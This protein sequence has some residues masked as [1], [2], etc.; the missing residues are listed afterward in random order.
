MAVLN[1]EDYQ[2]AI[3]Q[4]GK[5]VSELNKTK[6]SKYGDTIIGDLE[7]L[8]HTTIADNKA[9]QLMFSVHQTDN[10]VTTSGF[11]RV[12]DDHDAYNYGTNMVIQSGGNMIVG[13]GESAQSFYDG[14][15]ISHTS[16]HMYLTSDAQMYFITNC[17]TLNGIADRKTVVLNA[18]P[19][20]YSTNTGTSSLG[21]TTYP[22]NNIIGDGIR[23]RYISSHLGYSPLI[24][25]DLSSSW[26]SEYPVGMNYD[27]TSVLNQQSSDKSW[28][29][30]VIKSICA[31]Y[32]NKKDVT[33]RGQLYPNSKGWFEIF[34]YDTSDLLNGYPSCVGT[35]RKHDTTLWMFSHSATNG[36]WRWWTNKP[37]LI[38]KTWTSQNYVNE[39][40]FNRLYCYDIG[41]AYIV[42]GNMNVTQGV[43]YGTTYTIGK[44]S[45]P[46]NALV[47]GYQQTP[48]GTSGSINVSILTDG[49]VQI[50]NYNST[51]TGVG[52]ARFSI[53]LAHI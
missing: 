47:S 36:D 16:E 31:K 50:Y 3:P 28:M 25:V 51:T 34:V 35:F 23:P 6:V 14:N 53:T 11:I 43:P 41:N 1:R 49:T 2:T 46:I 27:G 29:Q 7:L 39:T 13:S 24:W 33:F 21:T 26:N 10:D 17:G 48:I 32:P 38:S 45:F 18:T 4:L 20:L 19:S 42:H 15:I 12:Y 22:W 44:F 8:K 30:N 52:W 40:S 9:S 37:Q 5:S